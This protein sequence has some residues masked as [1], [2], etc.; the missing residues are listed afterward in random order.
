MEPMTNRFRPARRRVAC[1][2]LVALFLFL[3]TQASHAHPA[4]A[5]IDQAQ[6]ATG[7]FFG[8]ASTGQSFTAA[9]GNIVA[10]D[11]NL[12]ATPASTFPADFSFAIYHFRH[13]S[14][15]PRVE[16][17]HST[18]TFNLTAGVQHIELASPVTLTPGAKYILVIN[19]PT[20]LVSEDYFAAGAGAGNLYSGGAL[21]GAPRSPNNAF[22][23]A[24]E[25]RDWFFRTYTTLPNAVVPPPVDITPPNTTI[26]AAVDGNSAAIANGGVTASNAATFTFSGTDD[27]G[28]TS[29]ECRLDAGAYTP[30]TSPANHSA[31]AVG[32]HQFQ[33]RAKDA[34]G[35][36]DATPATWD[37]TRGGAVHAQELLDQQQ[38]VTGVFFPTDS[39]AQS[40]TPSGTNIIA[41]DIRIVQVGA[42]G[43]PLPANF[44]FEIRLFSDW[45]LLLSHGPIRLWAGTHHIELPSQLSVLP[46][47]KYALIVTDPSGN[48]FFQ[49]YAVEGTGTDAYG[50]GAAIVNHQT[51][52]RAESASHDL[53]FRIYT[54]FIDG[55][56]DS[57]NDAD[58]NCPL[59]ANANQHNTD[60]DALGDA[61]D[62]D[63]D[64]DG[65]LDGA[66]AFPLNSA[67]SVDTDGDT[68]G[69][70]AD[71]DDDN[72]GV[73]DATETGSAGTPVGNT[74]GSD[75]LNAASTP[76]FCDGL[77]NDLN[78]GI[79]EGFP[80]T[81]GDLLADCV[82]PDDDGD[83]VL[84]GA[85]AFPLNPAESVDT[86]GDT[87]GNNADLDD[88]N[89]GVPDA[90]ETGSAGTPVGNTLGSDP[91]NAASKPEVC[92]GLDNDLNQGIDEGFP[93]ADGDLLADCVDPDDDND[94]VPD[95]TETGS[96]GTPAG[97]TLGSDPLNAA[98]RPE[99]CD[100]LDNDLN[101]GIDE[102]FPN[103][104]GDLLAD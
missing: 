61:C 36:T 39:W 20:P 89:D 6:T 17:V 7:S 32:S 50:R 102:G 11:I 77:D 24:G 67:E 99:V 56:G 27:V 59:V 71:L 57:V 72:D 85:D 13:P 83:G 65:V 60:G 9:G 5:V 64:G 49:D 1:G 90:T 80:N 100:N 78:Q 98:S 25:Q 94:G 42:G 97:N 82:D 37:W 103:T 33:V 52:A 46:G 12:M 66:D 101:Q 95:A 93:N 48:S 69:N 38:T 81:D 45:S 84:D 92:D 2:L 58:D 44:T 86:D 8:V 30:C 47:T 28:V 26:D 104:D 54:N 4:A 96:A 91:L 74:L 41:F 87:I 63:D 62:P 22:E 18:P 23:A 29:F 55:D 15:S 51:S 43:G 40:F 79:D 19:D 88:D 68:I 10:F 14:I 34:A 73:P 53:F 3:P 76:E 21:V 16:L 75:P 70:N 31:L 35:N